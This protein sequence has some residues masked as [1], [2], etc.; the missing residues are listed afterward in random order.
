[1]KGREHGLQGSTSPSTGKPGL[2][3]HTILDQGGGEHFVTLIKS[4]GRNPR[5]RFRNTDVPDTSTPE[6]QDQIRDQL[7]LHSGQ[8]SVAVP[9][10]A[11][12]GSLKSRPQPAQ[13]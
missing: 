8:R 3:S 12:G 5:S 13:M 7:L 4:K 10:V 2:P 6:R 1:M 11:P 9:A